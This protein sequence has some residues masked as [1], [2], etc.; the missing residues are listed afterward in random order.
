MALLVAMPSGLPGGKGRTKTGR[1][2]RGRQGRGQRGEPPQDWR[3]RAR[4][5]RGLATY[6]QGR[7]AGFVAGR[8][9]ARLHLDLQA[10]GALS[11]KEW[12]AMAATVAARVPASPCRSDA[13]PLEHEVLAHPLT[14]LGGSCS[15][16]AL[17]LVG[18][19]VW[20]LVRAEVPGG[21]A[22]SV[23]S[24][25]GGTV[26]APMGA[27]RVYGLGGVLL[28]SL[29]CPSSEGLYAVP[30]GAVVPMPVPVR[31]PGCFPMRFTMYAREPT[32]LLSRA[33]KKGEGAQNRTAP[34]CPKTQATPTRAAPNK[35]PARQVHRTPNKRSAVGQTQQGGEGRCAASRSAAQGRR[36]ASN[37]MLRERRRQQPSR[38]R[39]ASPGHR[40]KPFS[41][42]VA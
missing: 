32:G 18:A 29:H 9:V 42:P 20:V 24:T 21:M 13:L 28:R 8:R 33:S 40:R 23:P 12:R 10:R 26:S 35:R 39:P 25:A 15:F 19:V 11:Y 2:P 6:R 17:A 22:A 27:V 3:W 34:Y 1:R 14:C 7:R 16:D 31:L 36:Q 37:N 38:I 5:L 30:S 4:D 41:K